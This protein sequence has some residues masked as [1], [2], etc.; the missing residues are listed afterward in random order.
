M[1]KGNHGKKLTEK[2][3]KKLTDLIEDYPSKTAMA[4]NIG[5]DRNV[6]DRIMVYKSGS[7]QSIEK[8]KTFLHAQCA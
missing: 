5:V 4:L 3:V 6:L 7:V 8:I 2:D 1:G